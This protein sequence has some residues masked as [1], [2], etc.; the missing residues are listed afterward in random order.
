MRVVHINSDEV[1]G[2][3]ARA[4]TRLHRGLI[5]LGVDS[6]LVV[7]R[8]RTDASE[9]HGPSGE[10]SNVLLERGRQ[11]IDRLPLRL[12]HGPIKTAWSNG[13]VPNPHLRKTVEK[14][15]PDL[16]ILHWGGSG[17]LPSKLPD[18]LSMPV[19]WVL[20]DMAPFTGGCHYDRGCGRFKT[21]C[22]HCPILQSS[23]ARDLSASVLKRKLRY[24]R[25][26][27]Q[28]VIAP[29]RWMA[30][31]ARESLLFRDRRVQ[32]IHH[33]H[34]LELFAPT[35]KSTA[36]RILGWPDQTRIVLFGAVHGGSDPRKGFSLLSEALR[37]PL[38]NNRKKP[39]ELRVFGASRGP[40]PGSDHALHYEGQITDD[41]HM[42]LLYSA[43]DVVVVPSLQEAFGLTASEAHCCG[44]PVVGFAGTGLG[45]IV[46]HERTGY[47]AE[48][49]S[50][51]DLAW[52]IH[53]VLDLNSRLHQLSANARARAEAHFSLTRQAEAYL[54]LYRS[55]TAR[56]IDAP[57]LPSFKPENLP[58][59]AVASS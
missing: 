50:A 37:R 57:P 42:A 3:A 24:M 33:P 48:P 14:L 31:Q 16:V 25:K 44:T 4:A 8:R 47:L 26:S 22:G 1:A 30:R 18:K 58:V 56:S 55:I 7:Q 54:K 46:E 11:S 21:G 28:A 32:C 59:A 23:S 13:W 38:L 2:G 9:V 40:K 36:R 5:E 43:A 12:R 29:S 19:F 41:V 20:H 34:D 49:G 52:G 45:D 6:H 35:A 51:D 15:R 27:P 17:F 39:C 53:W 10:L